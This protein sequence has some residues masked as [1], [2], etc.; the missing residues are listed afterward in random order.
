MLIPA[1]PVIQREHPNEA[2]TVPWVLTSYLLVGA[3]TTP[4]VG[5]LSGIVM[6]KCYLLTIQ[7]RNIQP[8]QFSCDHFVFVSG[9]HI[10]CWHLGRL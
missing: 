7:P 10:C 5:G 6:K 1:L 4:V 9:W 2:S 3:V 8:F